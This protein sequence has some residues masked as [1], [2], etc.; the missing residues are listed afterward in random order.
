MSQYGSKWC[1]GSTRPTHMINTRQGEGHGEEKNEIAP[2]H[3][4]LIFHDY[5]A[6]PHSVHFQLPFYCLFADDGDGA[7]MTMPKPLGVQLWLGK[8]LVR[9]CDFAGNTLPRTK[10]L[11]LVGW[12]SFLP[13]LSPFRAIY[14]I[15]LP[16]YDLLF[17]YILPMRTF[18]SRHPS[19]R[20]SPYK[21]P[22]N[23]QNNFKFPPSQALTQDAVPA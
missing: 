1:F 11:A 20:Q 9:S 13:C 5:V 2:Q 15:L 14:S 17:N 16:I 18:P 3:V 6:P 7:M 21:I 4:V 8:N 23:T 19:F 10:Y 22:T 12:W